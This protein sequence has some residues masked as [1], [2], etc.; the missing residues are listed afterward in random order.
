[1]LCFKTPL[2]ERLELPSEFA[3]RGVKRIEVAVVATEV[4]QSVGNSRR[5]RDA[6]AGHKFPAQR[7][8]QTVKRIKAPVSASHIHEVAHDSRRGDHITVGVKF[9]LH[10]WQAQP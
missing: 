9:P 5:G 1:M 8:R 3:V 4:H 2:T 6:A 10:M 7:A